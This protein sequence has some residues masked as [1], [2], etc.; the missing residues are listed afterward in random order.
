ML[1]SAITSKQNP[2]K[3]KPTKYDKRTSFLKK[4]YLC[5]TIITSKAMAEKIPKTNREC[6]AL[7]D[8]ML[9]EEEKQ[10]II[11]KGTDELHFTLGFIIIPT[12]SLQSF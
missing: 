3:E 12:T 4:L 2:R 8:E 9:S 1:S 6:Y 5:A 10:Y 7:L 11:E